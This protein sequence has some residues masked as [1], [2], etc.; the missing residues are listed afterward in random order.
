MTTKISTGLAN[1]LLG[2]G[3]VRHALANSVLRV[4]SGDTQ[5]TTAD[6]AVPGGAVLLAEFTVDG[7]GDGL[8]L[9]STA[10][11]GVISKN[12]DEAWRA[13]ALA[14]GVATWFRWCL[15]NDTGVASSTAV[16]IQG[17]VNTAGAELN[18]SS[19]NFTVG[20]IQKVD[21]F[22]VAMPAS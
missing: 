20:A 2:V 6:S 13:T 9:A 5:P 22:A 18:F 15:P 4:Y 8:N 19:V 3:S 11:G 16:R 7:E 21:Y 1:Y 10:T 12:P 14:N 17:S